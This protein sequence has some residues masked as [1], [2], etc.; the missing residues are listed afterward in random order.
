MNE[1]FEEC[2]DCGVKLPTFDGDNRP[3]H[4]YIGASASCWDM[5]SNLWGANDPPLAP[6]PLNGLILDGY[7]VQ[8]H[9]TES[10]AAIQSVAVHLLAMYGVLRRAV[11]PER[12]QWIR[13]RAVRPMKIHRHKRWHWLEPLDQSSLLTVCDIVDPTDPAERARV[14]Q[15]YVTEVAEL[16]LAA[17]EADARDWFDRF[18][19]G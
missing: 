7:C 16:W 2:P 11:P 15:D 5:F 4:A 19:A 8:H 1:Q 10:P 18:I 9:G 12:A 14:A 6:M 3:R 17:Y 13:E